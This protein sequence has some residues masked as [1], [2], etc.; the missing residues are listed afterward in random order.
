MADLPKGVRRA[1]ITGAL[2]V[3]FAAASLA[4][5]ALN[6]LGLTE[7]AART[8]VMN[9]AK[10]S[11]SS[12]QSAIATAGTRAFLKLP[13]PARAAAATGLFAWAKAYVN[14]PAFKASYAAHR[15][16]MIPSERQYALTVQQQVKKEI[17]EQ[18]SL[19]ES[20]SQAAEKMPPAERAVMLEQVKTARAQSTNPA[21]IK[22][23]E[24]TRTAE[25]ERESQSRRVMADEV[26]KK[27][28]GDP[29]VLLARRLH[30]FLDATADV[31]F[32]ARTIS[33]TLGSDGIEF[34]DRADRA[35]PWMWQLAVIV[36]PEA[37]GAA[38]TAALAW[39]KEIER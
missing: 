1:V 33:L 39:L 19:M 3:S 26:D 31:N 13:R 32:A 28:P 15:N 22:Q 27:T 11:S 12:R 7:A 18:L 23:L 34:I 9:E 8:F 4:Q 10:G 17:D 20:L 30:E 2:A 24:A 21:Y 25:R 35:K 36:G 38:R 29:N 5:T 37:T 6:Q 14:S 16:G